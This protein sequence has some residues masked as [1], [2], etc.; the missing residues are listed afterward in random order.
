VPADTPNISL[1]F[2]V[3]NLPQMP[4]LACAIFGQ[5]IRP[6]TAL[7]GKVRCSPGKLEFNENVGIKNVT[8]E[9]L[10]GSEPLDATIGRIK[11]RNTKWDDSINTKKKIKTFRNEKQIK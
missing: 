7:K 4:S 10:A 9:L 11:E 6:T 2:D 8:L 1:E 5:Q 3:E